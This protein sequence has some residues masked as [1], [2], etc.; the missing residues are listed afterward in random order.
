MKTGAS[1]VTQEGGEGGVSLPDEWPGPS[2][3]RHPEG[4]T[5]GFVTLTKD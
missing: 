2:C 5:E 3:A 4:A 1:T